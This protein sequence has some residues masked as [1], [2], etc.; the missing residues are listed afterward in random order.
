[1]V[2]SENANGLAAFSNL[3]SSLVLFG[4][5]EPGGLQGPQ[6]TRERSAWRWSGWAAA[7]PA[8]SSPS[9]STAPATG[10][11]LANASA[12]LPF[13]PS[14]AAQRVEDDLVDVEVAAGGQV[15]GH[16]LA[17]QP[18]PGLAGHVD[19]PGL[20]P[21]GPLDRPA[22][23]V[24]AGDGPAVVVLAQPDVTVVFGDDGRTQ[25]LLW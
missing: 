24:R 4:Q 25:A 2:S 7:G 17:G 21:T 22:Q 9:S 8:P 23:G 19:R 3:R 15:A 20:A 5:L 6:L 10:E 16:D 18:G 1:M 12:F 11:N 13:G 14:A